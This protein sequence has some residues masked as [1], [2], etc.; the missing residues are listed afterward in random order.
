MNS[1]T[2]CLYSA[3]HYPFNRKICGLYPLERLIRVLHETGIRRIYLDLCHIEQRFFDKR[4]RPRL[5][6]LNDIEFINEP[7]TETA[8]SFYR[9]PTNMFMLKQYFDRW[10]QFFVE[11]ESVIVPIVND[12][13]FPLKK[14]KDLKRASILIRKTL[15]PSTHE[16]QAVIKY[17]RVL[18]AVSSRL[19]TMGVSPAFFTITNFFLTIASVLF[20]LNDEHWSISLAGM[21]LLAISLFDGISIQIARL[22][23][24]DTPG[25]RN[26]VLLC[27][28]L[29]TLV[30]LAAATYLYVKYFEGILAIV[31][32]ALLIAG[33]INYIIVNAMYLRH[34]RALRFIRRYRQDFLDNLPVSKTMSSLARTLSFLTRKEFYITL[35]VVISITGEL[36]YA[37]PVAA[38]GLVTG[39][40]FLLTIIARY[41][42]SPVRV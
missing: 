26:L 8:A 28:H 1:T 27:D 19:S 4:I 17:R 18:A 9:I 5:I 7:C 3:Y 29:A 41:S 12:E 37:V 25:L 39:T 2:A 10:D 20:I 35:L 6:D 13:Q 38:I 34:C 11:Q 40:L 15:M 32:P 22:A 42:T 30:F 14:G 33:L 36:H 23:Y 24:K 31:F 21:M 16:G